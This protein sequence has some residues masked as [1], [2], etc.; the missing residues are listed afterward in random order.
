MQPSAFS[1]LLDERLVAAIRAP[2]AELAVEASRAVV[3]GG[4][5]LIE[6]TFTIP[7]APRAIAELAQDGDHT[8][9]AGTVL[10]AEQ[11]RLALEAGARFLI[12]PNLTA[13]VAAAARRAGVMYGPG[14]YTTSEIVAA[15]DAGAHVIK[16]YPV[17]VAGGPAYIRV[18]RDPLPDVPMLAAGGT[19]LDNTLAFLEAGCLGVGLGASLADPRL[20]AAGDVSEIKRRARAFVALVAGAEVAPRAGA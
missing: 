18:V 11:A 5:R 3:R 20:A 2:S 7:D 6:V 14:A 4:I 1:Q 19:N 12:A 15:R 9:G 8:V 17:G 16:V 10:T 13:E